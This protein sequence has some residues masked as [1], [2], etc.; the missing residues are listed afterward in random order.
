MKM[1]WVKITSDYMRKRMARNS[2]NNTKP[3]LRINSLQLLS[4]R[5]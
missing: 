1:R 2:H 3:K 4:S 5:G